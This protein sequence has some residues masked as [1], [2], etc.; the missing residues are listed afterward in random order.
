MVLIWEK[1]TAKAFLNDCF[2][3]RVIPIKCNKKTKPTEAAKNP[4]DKQSVGHDTLRDDG[5]QFCLQTEQSQL[6][7]IQSVPVSIRCSTETRKPCTAWWFTDCHWL[8]PCVTAS[9]LASKGDILVSRPCMF[10][11]LPFEKWETL[12]T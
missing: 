11:R 6:E 4:L 5:A 8:I 7:C 1:G 9:K 10:E 2:E 12:E 3:N